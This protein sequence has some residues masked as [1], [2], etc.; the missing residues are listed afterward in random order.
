MRE[1]HCGNLLVLHWLRFHHHYPEILQRPITN[2]QYQAVLLINSKEVPIHSKQFKNSPMQ[3]EHLVSDHPRSMED[4]WMIFHVS[5]M[6]S[7]RSL[8]IHDKVLHNRKLPN[9]C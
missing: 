3:V 5:C 7:G 9:S 2:Q 6:I 1:T 4:H 8:I